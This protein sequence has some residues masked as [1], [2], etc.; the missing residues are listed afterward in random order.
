MQLFRNYKLSQ[1][2]QQMMKQE[3]API[4][5]PSVYS[6]RKHLVSKDCKGW[7]REFRKLGKWCK[8]NVLKYVQFCQNV[9]MQI[10][11]KGR[12]YRELKNKLFIILKYLVDGCMMSLSLV[13]TNNEQSG[14]SDRLRF[15]DVRARLWLP[16]GT[17]QWGSRHQNYPKGWG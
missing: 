9:F 15:M 3:L 14:G 7:T 4:S 17:M 1:N 10:Q 2:S 6:E 11:L 8:K 16:Q 5:S 12:E 13:L